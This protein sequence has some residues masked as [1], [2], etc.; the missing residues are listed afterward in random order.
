MTITF[1]A[2]CSLLQSIE[3]ICTR[4]PRL[5]KVR[6]K[7]C[8]QHIVSNWFCNHRYALD[9]A[10]TNGG[11]VLSALFPHR[12]KDRVYGLQ[13]PLLA[14]KLVKLLRFNNSHR[15][16]FDGWKT[17]ALGD[18]GVYTERTMKS[19]DGT[20]TTKHEIPIERIDCLLVQLAAKYRFSDRVIREQRD[21]HV[22]TDTELKDILVRLESWEAKWLVR[23]LLRDYCTIELDE[24]FVLQQYHFLLP[25]LLMFQNNFDAVFGM[26]R[27]ELGCYPSVPDPLEEQSMRIEAAQKLK[28][29]I[30]VKVRY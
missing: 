6:E 22:E 1:G 14:K 30:G 5:T 18:L 28:V 29:M 7:E 3:N 16:L 12:R 24:K 26:L 21:W 4:K 8:V 10:D 19:W 17:G 15:V 25:D 27:G 23:L 9:D 20:F 11:A 13:A 2:I